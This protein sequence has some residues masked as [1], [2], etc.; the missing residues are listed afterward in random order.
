MKIRSKNMSYTVKDPFC[1]FYLYST[2]KI[3]FMCTSD[4]F[5]DLCDQDSQF[6]YCK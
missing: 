2:M 5:S 3:I 4:I 1:E 6:V